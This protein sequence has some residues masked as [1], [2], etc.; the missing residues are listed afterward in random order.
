MRD[1]D[2]DARSAL[3]LGSRPR[4]DGVEPV[5]ST[6]TEGLVARGHEVTLCLRARLG[7][8]R[9]RGALLDEAHPDVVHD[10]RGFTALAMADRLQ[11][12]LVHTLHG[13]STTN[14]PASGQRAFVEREVPPPPDG[15][16]I[17][18]PAP[19]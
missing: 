15:D 18:L 14:T 6:L 12:P 13:Q 5:V 16:R 3:D 11:T 17:R 9:S 4:Y 19:R 1:A 7:V 8:R 10:H 2:P